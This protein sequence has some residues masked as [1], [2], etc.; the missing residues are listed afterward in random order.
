M[1]LH[2]LPAARVAASFLYF[3]K[4]RRPSLIMRA[5]TT[6]FATFIL[7]CMVLGQLANSDGYAGYKLNVREDGDPLAVLYE[8]E[9]A[10]PN[11][12]AL[13]WSCAR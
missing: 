13:P 2:S 4:C 11:V 7:P 10:T 5:F 6:V 3:S 9:N 1:S 8:T 12:S